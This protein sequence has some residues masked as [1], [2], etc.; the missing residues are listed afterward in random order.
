MTSPV[1]NKEG[2]TLA[3]APKEITV[4]VVQRGGRILLLRRAEGKQFDPGR[5]EFVSGF[6]KGAGSLQEQARAQ[7]TFETGL[8]PQLEKEGAAF[9]MHDEYGAWKIHPFLFSAGAGDVRIRKGDYTEFRWVKPDELAR[10]E[11]VNELGRNL[12]SL[13]LW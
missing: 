13:E 10:F 5:W 4:S 8:Q 9:E 2:R 7:V 1:L 6:V 3:P 12:T 11:C